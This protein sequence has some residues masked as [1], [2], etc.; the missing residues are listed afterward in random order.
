MYTALD[1]TTACGIPATSVFTIHDLA[2]N[3]FWLV[4]VKNVHVL[5]R[6]SHL[7]LLS[8]KHWAEASIFSLF[9]RNDIAAFLYLHVPAIVM[10]RSPGTV[11]QKRSEC[12]WYTARI[13]I[14]N[15]SGSAYDDHP[16]P[17]RK[18]SEPHTRTMSISSFLHPGKLTMTS[19]A[20]AKLRV[21]ICHV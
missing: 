13:S 4:Q 11:F 5:Q 2:L 15:S 14:I 17:S 6:V 8:L 21:N 18:Q 19:I 12:K 3:V 9:S 1:Q 16:S 20:H 7:H 10:H